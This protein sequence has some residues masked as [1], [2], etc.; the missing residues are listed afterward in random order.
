MNNQKLEIQQ[1]MGNACTLI[2]QG[3]VLA[4]WKQPKPSQRL[5]LTALQADHPA[6]VAS[7]MRRTPNTRRFVVK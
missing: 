7:Y 1:A 5:D 6:L 3:K 2:H 4:T